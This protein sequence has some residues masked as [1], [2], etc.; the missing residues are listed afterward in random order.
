L[1]KKVIIN[2][3]LLLLGCNV[4]IAQQF[5]GFVVAATI[6]DGDTIP[7]ITLPEIKVFAPLKFKTKSEAIQFTKLMRQVKTVYPLARIAA[8]KMQE[9][10]NVIANVSSASE[11][12]KIMKNAEEDLKKQF[13]KEI[14]KLTFSQGKILIKLIDRETKSS[15]YDI[16]A[17]FRG[18]LIAMF[19]Q[20]FGSIFGMNLKVKYDPYNTDRDIE[21]IVQMIENGAL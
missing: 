6:I 13:E 19:W 1:G 4:N 16:I 21:R 20:S 14:R 3:L 7:V 10:N 17:E 8:I 5:K 15:A 2:I 18:N 11:K 12:R 9:Y